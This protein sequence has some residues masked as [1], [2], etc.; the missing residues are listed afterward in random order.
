MH[1]GA[2]E[3]RKT[4]DAANKAKIKANVYDNITRE[5]NERLPPPA[6]VKTLLTPQ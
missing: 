3:I 5:Y 4:R 2:E 6:T 1:K